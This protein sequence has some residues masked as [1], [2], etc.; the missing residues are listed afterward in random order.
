MNST[1]K[2]PRCGSAGIVTR[3]YASKAGGVLG[4]VAG[5]AAA[6]NDSDNSPPPGNIGGAILVALIGGAA[7]CTTGA[8]MGRAI[9]EAV[10]DNNECV[11][12][13][14]AFSSSSSA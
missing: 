8:V 13:G 10:L 2:C 11:S 6:L 7:G 3:N 9:D 14:Q 4:I 12:C 5:A 1:P